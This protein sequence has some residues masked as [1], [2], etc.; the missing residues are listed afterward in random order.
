MTDFSGQDA[1]SSTR[2]LRWLVRKMTGVIVIIRRVLRINCSAFKEP[3]GHE[4][5]VKLG[6]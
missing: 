3:L 4:L 5:T 1:L 6:H 2:V